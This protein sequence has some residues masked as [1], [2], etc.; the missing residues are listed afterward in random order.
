MAR[1]LDFYHTPIQIIRAYNAILDKT[2]IEGFVRFPYLDTSGNITIGKGRKIPNKDIEIFLQDDTVQPYDWIKHDTRNGDEGK[3]SSGEISKYFKKLISLEP[4][5]KK[6][7]KRHTANYYNNIGLNYRLILLKTDINKIHNSIMF[8]KTHN[9]KGAF[10]NYYQ[11]PKGIQLQLME[12][13]YNQGISGLKEKLPKC[14]HYLVSSA[15]G[16]MTEYIK[17]NPNYEKVLKSLQTIYYFSLCSIPGV[18]N[19]R[20]NIFRNKINDVIKQIKN[21]YGLKK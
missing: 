14:Y 15:D 20:N 6:T 16:A 10:L 18:S 9:L 2:N 19:E 4:E 8:E 3:V 17:P 21:K 5:Q 11:Y 7:S 13:A 1:L 12:L